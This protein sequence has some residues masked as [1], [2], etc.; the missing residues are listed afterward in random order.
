MPTEP[1]CGDQVIYQ[2]KLF[3]LA[4]IVTMTDGTVKY[5]IRQAHWGPGWH[6]L[7]NKK[8]ILLDPPFMA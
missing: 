2:G 3:W 6:L 7:V 5:L 4:V 8:D 1:R